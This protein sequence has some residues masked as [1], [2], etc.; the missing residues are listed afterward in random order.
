MPPWNDAGAR[1]APGAPP[2]PGEGAEWDAADARFGRR[3]SRFEAADARFRALSDAL[4]AY[5][6]AVGVMVDAGVAVADA[7]A[8]FF[9]EKGGAAGAA[10]G[11]GSAGKSAGSGLGSVGSGLGLAGGGEEEGGADAGGGAGGFGEKGVEKAGEKNIPGAFRAAQMSIRSKWTLDVQSRFDEEVY[12][13]VKDSLDQFPEVRN[14]IKQRDA[15]KVEMAKRQKKLKDTGARVKD[16]QRKW[17]EC[18]DRFKMFDDEV[19]QRF[20]VIDRGQAGLVAKPLRLLVLLLDEF[21]RDVAGAMGDVVMQ[22]RETASTAVVREFSPPPRHDGHGSTTP[23]GVEDEGWD[24]SFPG[25][26]P[27]SSGN[28]VRSDIVAS[29]SKTAKGAV[30]HQRTQSALPPARLV[31][32][33]SNLS[34][35]RA[36]S[37]PPHA[38]VSGG[39]ARGVGGGGGGGV[40]GSGA[41]STRPALPSDFGEGGGGG[42]GSGRALLSSL[43]IGQLTPSSLKAVAAMDDVQSPD[44]GL[45]HS[46][47]GHDGTWDQDSRSE[48]QNVL[49]RLAATFEF[50]PTERNELA[51]HH[52]DIIEVY[53]RHASGWWLGRTNHVTGY[54]PQN[55]TRPLS[56]EEEVEFVQ[57]RSRRKRDRRRAHRRRDS[58]LSVSQSSLSATA[59]AAAAPGQAA[60]GGQTRP[61]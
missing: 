35:R 33:D 15:A 57:E 7:L 25:D 26:D 27:A 10:G 58:G 43:K 22:V 20:S 54:F 51:L 13:A 40:G 42:D 38:A 45:P 52:G 18:T 50:I 1:S 19:M 60:L 48:R 56:E 16:K 29:A 55:H 39:G 21:Y 41:G 44:A 8:D 23:A 30:G 14:Y 3:L 37:G 6:C 49:M 17:R 47:N 5:R 32:S 36:A 11:A 2:P 59:A 31:S 46:D 12:K 53:E 34:T 24:D 28:A 4:D 61:P 9:G